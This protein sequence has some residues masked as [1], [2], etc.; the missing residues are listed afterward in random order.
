MSY[1]TEEEIA[2]YFG[3]PDIMA[4]DL[5]GLFNCMGTSDHEELLNQFCRIMKC[6]RDVASF[7]LESAAWNVEKAVNT[8]LTTVG[9]KTQIRSQTS[10]PRAVFD[11]SCVIPQGLKVVTG[12]VLNCSWRFKN[13]GQSSWPADAHIMHIDGHHFGAGGRAPLAA[14]A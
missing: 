3:G 7:F 2:R 8:F 11:P 10:P 12:S 14:E 9:S 5:I 6:E 4:E 13:V 1:R